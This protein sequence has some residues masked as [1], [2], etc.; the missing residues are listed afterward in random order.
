M[1]ELFA[2][3]CSGTFFGAAV[4]VSIAQHPASLEAGGDVPGKF[5]P[6]M[7]RRAAPMQIALAVAGTISALVVWI[8]TDAV[9]WAVGSIAL[10][11]VIPIT[12]LV[13]KPINDALLSPENDPGSAETS[14]L[15]RAWGIRHWLRSIASGIAFVLFLIGIEL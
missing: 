13:I 10:F 9:I 1:I 3:F 14:Q 6:P 2:L 5:F 7:Y 4:Y 11:S 15:L 8:Q 12:L